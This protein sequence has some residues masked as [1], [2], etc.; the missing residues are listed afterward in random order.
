MLLLEEGEPL[1]GYL[2]VKLIP[3]LSPLMG[4]HRPGLATDQVSCPKVPSVPSC[5]GSLL[6]AVAVLPLCR[7][8]RS[9][10][11]CQERIPGPP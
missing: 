4:D 8:D 5:L 2:C 7:G 1:A 3:E 6:K 10:C 11:K 9:F